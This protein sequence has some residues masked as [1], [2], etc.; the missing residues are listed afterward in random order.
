MSLS[1]PRRI[2]IFVVSGLIFGLW[3]VMYSSFE[4]ARNRKRAAAC[5][6][7]LKQVGLATMQYCRDYDELHPLANRWSQILFPYAKS[8]A[9]FHCPSVIHFGYS[10]NS[11]LDALSMNRVKA[12]MTTPLFFDSSALQQFQHDSGTSWPRDA[13]HP[14]GNAVLFDDGHVKFM[15]QKPI[16]RSFAAPMQKSKSKYIPKSSKGKTRKIN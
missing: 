10:M 15:K 5:M 11:N 13:R 9:I 6:I 2:E 16:F 8:D 3:F 4:S 7:N 12:T 14:I 1:K